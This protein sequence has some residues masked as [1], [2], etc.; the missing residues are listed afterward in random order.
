METCINYTDT[1]TAFISSDEQKWISR[2]HK[3]KQERPDEVVIIREPQNND[4]CIYAKIPP[5]W[6]KV[7]PKRIYSEEQIEKFREQM[8]RVRDLSQTQPRHGESGH[9]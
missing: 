8:N 2:I 1:K 5:S 7:N 6:V 9:D 4:G 3:L